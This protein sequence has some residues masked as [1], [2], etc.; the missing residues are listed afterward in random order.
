MASHNK[1]NLPVS[2]GV[3]FSLK[4]CRNFAIDPKLTLRWLLYTAGFRRVRLMSYWNEHEKTPGE[5]DFSQLD[6]QIAMAEKAEAIVTLC[7]GARQ[8]RWPENHWPEWAWEADTDERTEA[9]LQYI[10]AVVS[11]YR[12]R[13]C[14]VSYQLE[15]EALLKSF[16]E[17]GEV[18]RQRLRQ[19]Y[20]LV[21]SLDASRPT[22]M[23]TSTSWG[24]PLRQ[25]IPDIVGFSYYQVLY[26]DGGYTTALHRPWLD[27]LRAV[28]IKLLDGKSS[29]IHEL[30]LEPWGPTAIWKMPAEEQDK[31]MS[32]GQIKKNLEL[33]RKT[34]LSPIDLWGGE[35][36]YWRLKKHNDASIWQAV[37][38]T[39]Q[40]QAG[41]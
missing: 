33:A 40:E 38:E 20:N 36:W 4:Q 26:R 7:L 31:S 6:W 16:G 28:L 10:E 18:D 13:K 14:V 3:S 19:E 30:Q 37:K 12:N 39:L 11:R 5:Y 8:P 1:A 25:P 29:F 35:W 2:Y 21:K 24:I 32:R 9:L 23:T 34:G 27:R 15:N 22:I 41:N 17:R